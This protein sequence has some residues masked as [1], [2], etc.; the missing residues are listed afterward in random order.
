MNKTAFDFVSILLAFQTIKESKLLTENQKQKIYTD[1]LRAL[2][3][4]VFCSTCIDTMKIVEEVLKNAQTKAAPKKSTEGIHAP[5]EG[6]EG[7]SELLRKTSADPRGS[8]V[9]K[10]VVKKA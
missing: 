3:P 1:M 10:A 7:K 9:K 6:S 5:T 8:R 4:D 2:P